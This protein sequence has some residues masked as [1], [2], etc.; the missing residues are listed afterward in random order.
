MIYIFIAI[1]GKSI[2]VNYR[3]S[4]GHLFLLKQI[5]IFTRKSSRND[6]LHGDTR[7]VD[8]SNDT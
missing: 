3:I 4:Q 8:D 7:K 5:V 6:F 1:Y 2:D